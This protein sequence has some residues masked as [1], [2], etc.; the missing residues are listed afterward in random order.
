V[1]RGV[2]KEREAWCLNPG[3]LLIYTGPSYGL[4]DIPSDRVEDDPGCTGHLSSGVNHL[5]LCLNIHTNPR[6]ERWLR[7]LA[8]GGSIGWI[9]H[10]NHITVAGEK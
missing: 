10:N 9:P 6:M 3:D 2:R 7:V 8:S 4:F 1:G 5:L